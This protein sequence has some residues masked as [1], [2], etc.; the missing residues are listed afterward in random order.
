MEKDKPTALIAAVLLGCVGVSAILAQPIMTEALVGQLGIAAPDAGLITA[1]EALGTAFGPVVALLWMPRVGRRTAAVFALAVVIA[2]NILS[3]YQTSFEALAAL[4][5]IVGFLGQGT[6]FALAMAIIAGTLQKDR[7]F[8]VLIAAQVILGVLCFLLLPM[9]RSAGVAGVLLPLLAVSG[10]ALLTVGWIPQATSGGT[11]HAAT[12]GA[13]GSL[14]PGL[15]TLAIM[16]IW[17]T[18]LGAIWAFVKLIGATGGISPPAVGQ[19]L[20][21]STAIATL[22]AVAA[23]VLGDRVGRIAPV[24]VAILM[25]LAMVALLHGEMS[26]LQFA[27][28][29]ATFQVFWNLTGPYLMGTIA[30]S[31]ST[32]RLSLL[33]PTAQIGGFFLG[34]VLVS[35]FLTGRSLLPANYVASVC[36]VLALALFLPAAIRLRG[37]KGAPA[38]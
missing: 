38:H 7:N 23:A 36:F 31:D 19:A 27:V 14:G 9:P 22:G 8:A 18:G 24:T 28:T 25:Q 2:G 4:R 3:S 21:L 11:A 35:P 1:L 12:G 13:G 37:V 16:L 10:A 34:P 29:A 30:L 26:W 6:A 33:I 20:A 5:F 32:G 17:C 15:Y